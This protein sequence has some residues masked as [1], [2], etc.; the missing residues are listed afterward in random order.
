MK[1]KP[2]TITLARLKEVLRYDPLT[3]EWIWLQGRFA[4]KCAGSVK[5][6]RRLI[7]VDWE[8][9]RAARLAWFYM[10]GEQPPPIV[11]H[12]DLDTLNDRWINLRA[13]NKSTNG[14]NATMRVRNKSGR[15]GVT[16]DKAREKWRAKIVYQYRCIE[17]GRF[18]TIEAAAAA[19]ECKAKELFGEFARV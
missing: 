13:A 11:D 2:I 6:G 8:R 1:A 3:G 18:D 5:E 7:M 15:K 9:H 14:A 10:T 17:L 12:R 19:Y 16:W 4:G